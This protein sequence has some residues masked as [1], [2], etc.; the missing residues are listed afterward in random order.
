MEP[1][2]LKKTF[3]QIGLL[4]ALCC[5]CILCY[6]LVLQMLKLPFRA[7]NDMLHKNESVMVLDFLIPEGTYLDEKTTIGEV[8]M[9]R[10]KK[11]ASFYETSLERLMELIPDRLRYAADAALFFFWS[12]IYMTF[13]RV[14]TFIGYGRAARISLLLGGGTYYFMPDFSRGRIDDI[15]FLSLP[16][17]ILIIRYWFRGREKTQKRR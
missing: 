10:Y 11:N 9:I 14:F 4:A 13:F 7:T 2:S 16:V 8:I 15:L 3:L 12:F 17:L 5:L 6:F 1:T